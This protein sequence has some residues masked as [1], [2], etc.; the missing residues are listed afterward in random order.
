MEAEDQPE[1][2]E[3]IGNEETS[4][5]VRSEGEACGQGRVPAGG[6]IE[7]APANEVHS[8]DQCKH[9]Q[10][11]GQSCRPVMNAEKFEA[12][13]DRPVKERRFFEIANAVSMKRH[14]IIAQHHLARRFSVHRI[15]IIQQCGTK[16]PRSIHGQP[17]NE[18]RNK[19]KW[20]SPKRSRFRRHTTAIQKNSPRG[21]G[22]RRM[23]MGIS[24]YTESSTIV[25]E[26]V[27]IALRWLLVS[28]NFVS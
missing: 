16:Y 19:I 23:T 22:M 5:D 24:I 20:R 9:S 15:R 12:H 10:C 4:E 21:R 7:S 27:T 8:D 25:P 17:E 18:E 11:K 1:P 26:S 13:R 3:N 14:P 6:F 28:S 2:H